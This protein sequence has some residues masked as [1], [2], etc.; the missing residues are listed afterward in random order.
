M[1]GMMGRTRRQF[2]N[3]LFLLALTALLTALVVQSGE[4]GT[5]DTTHR[6]Q[7]THSWW[8]SEPEVDPR[9][10]P[11][12]GIHGPDG[13][14]H[15][16]YGIGQSLLM[17]PADILG[18]YVERLPVFA[19]Y[20]DDPTVRN[21]VVSYSTN[22]LVCLLTALVCLRLLRLLGFSV[23]QKVAGV[24]A[25]LFCT[26]FLHYTQN[27]MENNYNLLLTLTG[28]TFQYEWFSRE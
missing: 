25:L 12:F 2:F 13:K 3:P 21:I 23:N 17:L 10:Y 9:D 4:L 27:L 24:L 1:P 22:A 5:S 11:E 15:G 26:T 8:T 16:W 6:L 28:L 14:L 18:T 7:A 19:G 20:D